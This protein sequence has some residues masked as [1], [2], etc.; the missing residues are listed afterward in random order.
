MRRASS[1]LLA[2][3]A[4]ACVPPKPPTPPPTAVVTV[5]NAAGATDC[6]Y[7]L[8]I[9]TSTQTSPAHVASAAFT[10]LESQVNADAATATCAGFLPAT[11]APASLLSNRVT[12]GLTP[13][14]TPLPP[15]PTRDQLLRVRACFQDCTVTTAQ[16]GTVPSWGPEI[17]MLASSADRQATYAVHKAAGATHFVIAVT[18]HYTAPGVAYPGGTACG[19]DWSTDPATLAA[20]VGEIV[21]AGLLP[22]VMLGGDEL[23]WATVRA[24]MPAWYGALKNSPDGDLTPY[25]VWCLGF[26][27]IVPLANANDDTVQDFIATTLAIRA[28]I[29]SGVQVVEYP[30]GWAFWGPTDA[31]FDLAGPGSYTSPA[32]QALDGVLQEFANDSPGNDPLPAITGATFDTEHGYTPKW[33]GDPTAWLQVFQIAARGPSPYTPPPDEPFNVPAVAVDGPQL[34][35]TVPV[36]ADRQGVRSYAAGVTTPRGRFYFVGFEIATYQW[37]HGQSTPDRIAKACGYIARVGYDAVA[38]GAVR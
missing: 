21:R 4:A 20:H 19:N 26:D 24:Q 10:V 1:L 36:S 9:G 28:V 6:T 13:A 15:T 32:G 11:Q 12:L 17:G 16:L 23:P 27:S 5:D 3:F 37:T 29:G 2:A 18:C 25:V 8:R 38:C 30:A 33:A 31:R 35:Q 14:V 7:T 34:G 22:V